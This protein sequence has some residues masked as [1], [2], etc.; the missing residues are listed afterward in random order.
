[1]TGSNACSCREYRRSRAIT[2]TYSKE[3]LQKEVQETPMTKLSQKYGVSDNAVKKWCKNYEI[4]LPP[5]RGH[6][7]KKKFENS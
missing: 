3:A 2:E 6:W 4:D 7:T 1:M 5:M